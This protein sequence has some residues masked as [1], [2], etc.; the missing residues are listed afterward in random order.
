MLIEVNLL[1][2]IS[3]V[4]RSRGQYYFYGLL[5]NLVYES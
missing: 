5:P 1:L 4:A 3:R 2:D